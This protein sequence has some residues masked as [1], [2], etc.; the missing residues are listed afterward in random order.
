MGASD[1]YGTDQLI[2]EKTESELQS[3]SKKKSD[4]LIVVTGA[5]WPDGLTASALAGVKGA[6]ICLVAGDRQG[7]PETG[8]WLSSEDRARIAET[9][10]KH[11]I[12]VGGDNVVPAAMEAEIKSIDGVRSIDRFSGDTRAQTAYDI[13]RKIA[14]STISG[15]AWGDTAIVV[16]GTTPADALSVSALAYGKKAPIFLT[17]DGC[18]DSNSMKALSGFSNVLI[19]GGSNAISSDEESRIRSSCSSSTVTR[20]AGIDRYETNRKILVYELQ[21]GFSLSSV[22]V[23]SGDEEHW[24]DALAGSPLCGSMNAPL[25]L[26]DGTDE[27]ASMLVATLAP[28]RDSITGGYILGGTAAISDSS[29][30][31]LNDLWK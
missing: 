4:Y 19:I 27:S 28:Y 12:I 17:T 13:Y 26:V 8:K 3:A 31:I 9:G 22:V 15:D 25:M 6:S 18:L 29:Q 10:A 5:N 20:L 16:T 24:P 11:I 1:R 30:L 2:V 7:N 23:A 21:H 14:G